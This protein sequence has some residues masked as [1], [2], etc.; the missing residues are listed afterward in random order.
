MMEAHL[1]GDL[2]FDEASK[3][4]RERARGDLFLFYIARRG[5]EK[6]EGAGESSSTREAAGDFS[7]RGAGL[8][9]APHA[10]EAE[11]LQR[12]QK[13]EAKNRNCAGRTQTKSALAPSQR[14]SHR[15]KEKQ[16]KQKDRNRSCLHVAD[17]ERRLLGLQPAPRRQRLRR[18]AFSLN[19][20]FPIFFCAARRNT[21]PLP[22]G[23][24]LR[25]VVVVG[26]R[27]AREPPLHEGGRLGAAGVAGRGMRGGGGGGGGRKGR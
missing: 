20:L 9:A 21:S 17:E 15:G 13:K 23:A 27:G 25:V 26:R 4:D 24:R 7:H 22:P 18:N 12:R 14:R 19:S 6:R 2:L 3:S 16:K 1:R 5:V 10:G 11:L 8:H